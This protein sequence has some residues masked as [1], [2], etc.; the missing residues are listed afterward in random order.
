MQFS[1]IGCY[2]PK[3]VQRPRFLYYHAI[4]HHILHAIARHLLFPII[5]FQ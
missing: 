4:S 1:T 2:H 3:N 5:K